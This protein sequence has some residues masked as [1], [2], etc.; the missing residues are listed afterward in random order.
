MR[1]TR[2]IKE[3]LQKGDVLLLVLC[4]IASLMGLVLVYS[5]T[6]WRESLHSTAIKQALF[7][8]LGIVAYV[9]VTF[10]DIEFLM[11]KWWWMFLALGLGVILTI[12]PWGMEAGG[13]KSWVFLPVIGKY[14]G[15]QP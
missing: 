4:V 10:I 9:W 7:L 5:A 2:T 13:N 8:C 3:F 11:E 1:P 6:Q 14:F 12:K 15:F